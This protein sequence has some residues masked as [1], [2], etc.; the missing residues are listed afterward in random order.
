VSAPLST[1]VAQVLVSLQIEL[2]SAFEAVMPHST[3]RGDRAAGPWLIALPMW[4]NLLQHVGDGLELGEAKA[5]ARVTNLDGL[6]RWGYLSVRSPTA[7]R[8]QK[9][10]RRQDTV[11]TLTRHG[12][13]ACELWP[14]VVADVEQQWAD[15][16]PTLVPTVHAAADAVTLS[17]PSY[18][19]VV[20]AVRTDV[21]LLAAAA[22]ESRVVG[23]GLAHDLSRLWLDLA[24]RHEEQAR[25]PLPLAATVLR[26]LEA[27]PVP[28]RDVAALAG[29]G[30][31]ATGSIV[32][33]LHR[34]H[35]A[36]IEPIP[37]GRGQQVRLLDLG[38]RARAGALRL[39]AEQPDDAPLRA[40]LE[41][42][43]GSPRLIEA[44]TPPDG[45]WRAQSPYS[46][47]TKA[48]L[49]DPRAHL[50]HAPLVLHRGGYPDGC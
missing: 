24:V 47:S 33:W 29:I 10:P 4:A 49:Q 17:T 30:T 27:Q 32:R 44:L 21:D 8:G 36:A 3:T 46:R 35:L 2:D 34:H 38:Q 42:V 12:R 13:L 28:H 7:P 6:R 31:E 22:T 20:G 11:L 18:L 1:L 14:Q 23:A 19:P 26:V 40:A 9:T 39:M 48:R 25:I 37:T 5:L 15:R 45:G 41:K 43:L 50:P 16:F